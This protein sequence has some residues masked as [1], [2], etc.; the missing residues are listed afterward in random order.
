[1]P[2]LTEIAKKEQPQKVLIWGEPGT[3]KTAL[4]ASLAEEGYNL[5]WVD[6]E[7]GLQTL[8]TH[9]PPE[10]H[11]QIDVVKIVDS[12]EKPNAIATCTKLLA[13][14]PQKICEAHGRIICAE[15][16]KTGAPTYE[17]DFSLLGEKDVVVF[18]S[19]SQISDS[20]KFQA[21][22]DLA[23]LDKLEYK[24]YERIGML[25]NIFFAAVQRMPFHVVC[26]AH[27]DTI[28]SGIDGKPQIIPTVGTRSYAGKVGKFFDHKVFTAV[29]N[30]KYVA[31]SSAM[32]NPK[33]RCSSRSDLAMETGNVTLGDLLKAKPKDG[34]Q[35]A[36]VQEVDDGN[37]GK[38][39]DP[40]QN[41]LQAK[42]GQLRK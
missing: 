15:C 38:V 9:V 11:D 27:A 34:G 6:T 39:S 35:S 36:N 3:G 25:L 14:K 1:M 23:D 37:G 28:D 32:F 7:N 16:N 29:V 24:H 41:P 18:D 31:A 10:F 4:A 20:A 33:V 22:K 42:L 26:I 13:L 5:H 40:K 2:K 30:K 8:L 12:K 17:K 19:V 21:T